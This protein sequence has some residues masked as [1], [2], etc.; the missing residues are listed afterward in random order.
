MKITSIK[1][2][3]VT[4]GSFSLLDLLDRHLNIFNERAILVIASKIVS[5]Y[6]GRVVK[7]QSVDKQKLIE[8]EAD[9]YLDPALNKY[10]MSLTI[11]NDI[12]IPNAGIDESN[13][14]GYLILWPKDAQ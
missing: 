7:A 14:A 10:G 1:T 13:G 3:K 12:L 8:K 9:Q 2:D 5:I 4:P 6:E 11:T